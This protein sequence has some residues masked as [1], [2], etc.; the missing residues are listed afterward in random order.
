MLTVM[1]LTIFIQPVSID[2]SET[3]AK[4]VLEQA[5][6][7]FAEA[8]MQVEFLPLQYADEVDEQPKARTLYLVNATWIEM[9]GVVPTIRGEA[10]IGGNYAYV[11]LGPWAKY[12]SKLV[13]HEVGHMLGLKHSWLGIMAN[14]YWNLL[15]WPVQTLDLASGF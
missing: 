9:L 1:L 14:G 7:Y 10:T 3:K 12:N 8:N 13:A 4:E 2:V 6:S 15:I 11:R 5:G